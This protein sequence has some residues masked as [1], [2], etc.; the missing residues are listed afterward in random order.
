[1]TEQALQIFNFSCIDRYARRA[2]MILL[3]LAVAAVIAHAQ[4]ET[5]APAN[6]NSNDSV[7]FD[8]PTNDDALLIVEGAKDADIF[9]LGRSIVVRGTV[10][11]GAMAFGGDVIVEGRVEG[12]V[13]AIG[14]SVYQR[15]GSYIGG[16]VMVI[17]GAYHHGKTAPGR[18]PESTTVM[19]AGY[20]P[21]LRRMMREPSLLLAP[22][23]SKTYLG[24]RLLAA[25]LWFVASLIL[26]AVMPATMSRAVARLQLTSL[27]VAL[28]G[29]LGALVLCVGLPVSLRMLPSVVGAVVG[30][31]ALAAT[32]AATLFGRVAIHAATGRWLERRFLPEGKRSESLALLLG[33]VVW[34]LLTSVPYVW[35]LM[36]AGLLV[37]SLGLALTARYKSRWTVS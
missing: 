8:K 10:K 20:E 5:P 21:E 32:A 7:R 30:I 31:I 11:K 33:A 12:D 3:A 16:D 27:H 18:N 36:V 19:F 37:A 4:S 6:N 34:T 22:Q 29:F 24:F 1:M 25:L 35:P 15:E 13:A 26:T 2:L 14:G 23:W 28:I 17:G 9:G